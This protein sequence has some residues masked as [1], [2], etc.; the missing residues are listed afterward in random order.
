MKLQSFSQFINEQLEYNKLPFTSKF[1]MSIAKKVNCFSGEHWFGIDHATGI[2]EIYAIAERELFTVVKKNDYIA[3]MTPFNPTLPALG[4]VASFTENIIAEGYRQD[5][6]Y[7][8]PE[9]SLKLRKINFYRHLND[10][11]SPFVSKTVFKMDE[12]STLTFPVIAKAEASWQSKGVKKFDTYEELIACEDQFDL[13]QEAFNIDKEYRAVVFKGKNDIAPK[14]LLVAMRTPDNGKA[15]SLRVSEG[16][17]HED[18]VKNES[19]KFSWTVMDIYNGDDNCPDIIEVGKLV[20]EACKVSP[21]MNMFAI[22]FAVDK[23]GRYWLIEANTQPGQNGITSHLIYLNIVKDFY[24]YK[25]SGNDIDKMRTYMYNA[26]EATKA[27]I[28][29]GYEMPECLMMNPDYWYGISIN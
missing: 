23:S 24:N 18:L 11:G 1:G 22:D 29:A 4:Y 17:E 9:D 28:I 5:L 26:V 15:K 6:I 10:I 8:L 3:G 21:G 25:I 7:N 19:S 12:V 27:Y 2:D 16:A 13:Y 14:I 20:L